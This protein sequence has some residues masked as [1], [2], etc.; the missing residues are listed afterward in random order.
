[1]GAG[2][3]FE[4]MRSHKSA[5]SLS[6]WHEN[7]Y[8]FLTDGAR[9]VRAFCRPSPCKVI[10]RTKDIKFD[11]RK[12]ELKI[13]VTVRPED[14]LKT[15]N[16][17]KGEELATEIFVP[18]VHFGH[19]S[20]VGKQQ[21]SLEQTM[22]GSDDGHMHPSGKTRLSAST[23]HLPSQVSLPAQ[24]H[25]SISSGISTAVNGSP[26]ISETVPKVI[27]DDVLDVEVRVSTGRWAVEGQIL[28]WWYDVPMHGESEREYNIEVRRRGGPISLQKRKPRWARKLCPDQGCCIM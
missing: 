25:S 15:T 7:P 27:E 12:A 28:K 26:I 9:G 8:T 23:V 21:G 13:S 3:V 24:V 19:K 2:A 16:G 5:D 6:G 18:L 1:M 14:R 4:E 22:D 10:G 20:V 11:I 17:D